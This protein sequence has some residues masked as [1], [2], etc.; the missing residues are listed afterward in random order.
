M[1]DG[2][3]GEV[4][5]AQLFVAV[6]WASSYTW[7]EAF[8]TQTLPDWLGS[9]TR[10]YAFFGGVPATTMSDTGTGSAALDHSSEH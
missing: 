1:I 4:L 9:H 8:W 3:T 6:L 5:K 2:L 7:A 10:A